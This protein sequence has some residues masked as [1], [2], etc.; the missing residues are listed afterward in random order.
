MST[1]AKCLRATLLA[2]TWVAAAAEAKAQDIDLDS[3]GHAQILRGTPAG[4]AGAWLD[5][6]AVGEADDRKDLI[7]GSPGWSAGT[8]RISILFKGPSH[9]GTANLDSLADATI[10]GNVPD[11]R[12]GSAT[13]SGFVFNNPAV[14]ANAPRDLI[15]A[16]EGTADVPGRVYVFA[17]PVRRGIHDASTARFVITG[18]AGEGFGARLGAADLDDDGLREVIVGAPGSQ[19]VYIFNLA[20]RTPGTIASSSANMIITADADL[21]GTGIGEVIEAG[22]DITGD[23]IYDLAIGAPRA[24]GARGT[25]LIVRGRDDGENWSFPGLITARTAASIV[26]TGNDPGDR[27]GQSLSFRDI[28]FADGGIRDLLIGA[29]GGDGSSSAPR[30]ESGEVYVL[31]GGSIVPGCNPH[32]AGARCVRSLSAPDVIYYGAAANLRTGEAVAGGD[33]TRDDPDDVVFA[34]PGGASFELYV[35]YGTRLRSTYGAVVDLARSGEVGRRIIG[36]GIRSMVV[37]E[38]TGEGAN[39]IVVGAPDAAGRDGLAYVAVSPKLRVSTRS[40]TLSAVQCGSVWSQV[41]VS[42]PSVIALP[43]EVKAKDG[44]LRAVPLSGSSV[45]AANV[46]F[47]IVASSVGLAEGTYTSTL[48]VVSTTRHLA[49]FIRITVTLNVQAPSPWQANAQSDFTGDG[50]GDLVLFSPRTGTW[51]VPGTPDVRLGAIGDLPVAGDFNGDRVAEPVVYRRSNSTWYFSAS[52]VAWGETGDIPVPADYDG[53]GTLDIA[54]YRP[55]N[56]TWLIR[57]R[58][59]V[60]WGSLGDVP[61]PADYDGDGAADMAIFAR[62][63]GEWRIRNQ[64][65]TSWG[66]SGDLPVPA[67]YNGDGRADIAV[68]RRGSGTWFVRGQF[69]VSWGSGADVPAP[70]DTNRDGRADLVVYRRA[71]GTWFVRDAVTGVTGSSS[72]G[73]TGDVPV[74]GMW[75]LLTATALDMNPDG[76]S[77]I[78]VWRP[79]NGTWFVKQSHN[80][81]ASYFSVDWGSGAMNDVP[82]SADFDGDRV[83]DIGVWRPGTGT[84][85]VLTSG[86][87]YNGRLTI[88]WGSGAVQ[89]IPVAADYDGD[90]RADVAVWRPASGTWFVRTSSSNYGGG[91]NIDWGSG[92]AGDVPQAGDYDGDGRADLA[93]WRPGTGI[94]FVLMSSSGYQ[95]FTTTEWGSGEAGDVPV[96]ADYDGDGRFDPAVYRAGLAT[97]HIRRSSTGATLSKEWGTKSDVPIVGDFDGDGQADITVWR[98]GTGGWHVSTSSSGFGGGFSVAWGSGSVNDVPIGGRAR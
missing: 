85:Y 58:S 55:S 92:A 30:P 33:I 77:E 4:E 14:I 2:L 20:G 17:G 12:F 1:P 27:A 39:D 64:G 24:D 9:V 78:A 70:I 47:R 21:T 16:A 81:Y 3:P 90:Q 6:A 61:V 50:C 63:S 31:W 49:M 69:S 25:V 34:A 65:T 94:W 88:Q 28:V 8:G 10:N 48:D 68:Y 22:G 74:V 91:F 86:D 87:S 26:V 84:W 75:S 11:G 95:R 46:P 38:A 51:H 71:T 37:W 23:G 83:M 13:A 62:G 89:D 67:D 43:W 96:A 45:A 29:P 40:I 52:S 57:G 97:W 66:T 53:D 54:V 73:T 32:A 18:S 41:D 79:G 76:R 60:T 7:V 15:I 72:A 59:P 44:W 98:P 93:I 56:G 82:L 19:R 80:N 36:S 42:N 5:A 35:V